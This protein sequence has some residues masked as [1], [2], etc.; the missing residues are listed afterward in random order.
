[1]EGKLA[2]AEAH[3]SVEVVAAQPGHVASSKHFLLPQNERA[4]G[5]M[6]HG[7]QLAPH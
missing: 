4:A 7:D 3:Y 6:N 1:M 2:V 5:G